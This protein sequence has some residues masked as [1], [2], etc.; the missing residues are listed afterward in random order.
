MA[1]QLARLGGGAFNLQQNSEMN[2][3]PFVDVM[4][5]LMIIFMVSLPVATVSLN[6]DLPP[7]GESVAEAP[8]TVITLERDG[9]L[10]IGEQRSS[11]AAL[12]GDLGRLGADPAADRLYVRAERGVRYGAF[13][14]VV[15]R[16]HETGFKK[17]G[18]VNEEL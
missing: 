13:L 3:T 17:V 18:L 15:D 5:V 2:V 9:D 14:A 10:F 7:A 16:L 6:M 4:L 1:A 8:P 12:S 11:L